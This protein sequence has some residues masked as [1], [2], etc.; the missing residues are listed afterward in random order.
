MIHVRL[1][2][3]AYI[4][5]ANLKHPTIFSCDLNYETFLGLSPHSLTLLSAEVNHNGRVMRLLKYL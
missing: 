4:L 5:N 1:Q 2:R 3:E